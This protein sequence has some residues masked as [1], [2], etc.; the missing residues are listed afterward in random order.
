MI[1]SGSFHV[2]TDH[3]E[4]AGRRLVE[5][6]EELRDIWQQLFFRYHSNTAA[7]ARRL[8]GS[9]SV[10]RNPRRYKVVLFRDRQ[11][12]VEHLQRIEPRIGVSVGYY[13]ESQKTA[14]FYIDD[15][16]KDD[17]YFHEVTHQLFAET[18]RVVS[19]VGVRGNAWIIEGVAMYM[20]SLRKMGHYYTAGGIDANRLQYARYRTLSQ[21]FYVP[22]E[23]LV[24]MGRQ[25]LQQH[26]DIR[27]L[28]SQSAGLATML[29]DYRRGVYRRALVDYLRVVY[30]GRDRVDSLASLASVPLADLDGQYLEFLNVTDADLAALADAPPA[31]NLSLGRTSVT[32][33]GMKHLKGQTLLEWLDVGNTTV[34]DDGLAALCS[35]TRLNHL[36]V[37]QT[38]I[39]D[40]SLETISNFRELEILDLTGT[41]ITDE[42][43]SH[44]RSLT[45]LKELW[46]G[47]TAI[48]D[49]GLVHLE[50][51]K[52]LET[53]DVG[54]TNVT[55]EGWD[56]LKKVLPSLN[57]DA[58]APE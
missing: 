3:S 26:E 18:G 25:D 34:G 35:A 30:Q 27:M 22:L 58:A 21:R 38:R 1:E 53:L 23:Q 55:I 31:R 13:L 7:L 46:I 49:A 33:E 52:C 12:Y 40:A 28:Y 57:T 44:L 36:I 47:D 48:G 10:S 16:P 56:R 42:G 19:G 54:G 9:T 32:D 6:L 4:Q 39:S 15:Q 17:T 37:E 24:A 41:A 11:E 51:L 14:Y 5:R 50:G 8:E 2:T 43:L 29:M 20:E 45:K